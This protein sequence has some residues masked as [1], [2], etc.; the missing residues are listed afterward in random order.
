[1][2]HVFSLTLATPAPG[3]AA[4]VASG[5]R[6]RISSLSRL[7]RNMVTRRFSFARRHG[8]YIC[9]SAVGRLRPPPVSLCSRFYVDLLKL[10]AP[11]A[12]QLQ[13]HCHFFH[14]AVYL[15]VQLQKFRPMCCPGFVDARPAAGESA[16][17]GRSRPEFLR[18]SWFNFRLTPWL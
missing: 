17:C 5:M 16:C 2:A 1:M 11:S 4:S 7:Q 13:Y 18:P 9:I 14:F 6:S 8:L 3:R 10:T 12:T 15:K